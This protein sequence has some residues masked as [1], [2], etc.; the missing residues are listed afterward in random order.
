MLRRATSPRV[1]KFLILAASVWQF[2]QHVFVSKVI[3]N[4]PGL[5]NVQATYTFFYS[6]ITHT[7]AVVQISILAGVIFAILLLRDFV[8]KK[9]LAYWF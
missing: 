7:Q 3:E 8:S 5:D 6:A 9:E 4:M 2:K 1:V